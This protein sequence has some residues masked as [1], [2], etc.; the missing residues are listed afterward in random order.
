MKKK[1][2]IGITTVVF[3]VVA[4]GVFANPT[5]FVARKQLNSAT[6]TVEYMFPGTATTTLTYDTWQDP[7]NST[8]IRNNAL[9]G[10]KLAIQLHA[11]ST[12]QNATSTV[13]N[14][15]YEY[16]ND[17]KDWYPVQLYNFSD[18]AT[19]TVMIKD[20]NIYR[21]TVSSSSVTAIPIAAPDNGLRDNIIVDV[22]VIARYI[23]A[24]FYLTRGNTG[25]AIDTQ[26]NGGVW[27]EFIPI[28]QQS[29]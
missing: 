7:N 16:S 12:I 2:I 15:R 14:W 9:D 1:Y 4:L 26:Q 5:F 18:R 22:P 3:L 20:I 29:E 10:L 13:L 21:M 25:A 28:K 17:N 27:A 6:T 8:I 19:T 11:S 23:R 24:V